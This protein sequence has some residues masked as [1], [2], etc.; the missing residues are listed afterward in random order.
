[1]TLAHRNRQRKVSASAQGARIGLITLVYLNRQR[2]V[3]TSVQREPKW[4]PITLTY[5][6]RLSI[7]IQIATISARSTLLSI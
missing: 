5:S 7:Q 6:F 4:A 1:M 3:S 2:K